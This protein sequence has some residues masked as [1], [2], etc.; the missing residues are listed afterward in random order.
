MSLVVKMPI[1]MRLMASRIADESVLES[2]SESDLIPESEDEE[3]S[4]SNS[5]A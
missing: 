4:G 3:I 1:I 5:E 2:V